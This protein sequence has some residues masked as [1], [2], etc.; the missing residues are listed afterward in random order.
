[1]TM[2]FPHYIRA[3][4]DPQAPITFDW[5]EETTNVFL[6]DARLAKRVGVGTARGI[7]ALSI[8]ITEWIVYR[9]S[10]LSNDP[11][12]PVYLEAAWVGLINW[13][14]MNVKHGAKIKD[15]TGPIRRPL[16]L[17]IR[18]LKENLSM[19][20]RGAFPA[21]ETV[22]LVFLARHVLTD[23]KP[24]LKWLDFALTRMA[25]HFAGDDMGTPVPREALDPD[26]DF[27]PE[28][29]G[30]LLARY[31]RTVSASSNPYLTLPPT[32]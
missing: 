31:L 4:V 23:S 9:F 6:E 30:E 28:Q 19:A 29:A 17:A 8:G 5:D 32:P 14:Y 12:P 26:F 27:K 11:M 24:F 7:A 13:D 25:M 20:S 10:A 3:G 1:M 2:T 18:T 16:F 21:E 22:Y 15:W